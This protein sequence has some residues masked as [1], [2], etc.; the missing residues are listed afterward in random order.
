[1][2]FSRVE[3]I[4]GGKIAPQSDL[5]VGATLHE[6]QAVNPCRKRKIRMMIEE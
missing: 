2:E 5:R 6:V 3:I 4:F 1:M